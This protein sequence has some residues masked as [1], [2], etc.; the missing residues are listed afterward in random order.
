M[1]RLFALAT[2]AVLLLA[3][4][5]LSTATGTQTFA[6]SDQVGIATLY[7]W[8]LYGCDTDTDCERMRGW[9]AARYYLGDDEGEPGAAQ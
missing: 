5:A 3:G 4:I 7:K 1:T 8:N 2:A 9:I 6:P